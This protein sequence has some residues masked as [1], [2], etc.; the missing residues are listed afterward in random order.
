MT[1]LAVI[2]WLSP[3][4]DYIASASELLEQVAS[5]QLIFADQRQE[6]LER[7]EAR[8]AELRRELRESGFIVEPGIHSFEAPSYLK[9]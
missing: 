8:L 1:Y 2:T 3:E 6:I 9:V 5:S 4:R 7:V